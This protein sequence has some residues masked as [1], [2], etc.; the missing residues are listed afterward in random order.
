MHNQ[1][2]DRPSLPGSNFTGVLLVVLLLL[3][4]QGCF[5]EGGFFDGLMECDASCLLAQYDD[6][7]CDPSDPCG[8]VGDGFCDVTYCAQAVDTYFDDADDCGVSAECAGSCGRGRFDACTCAPD[9]P[10]GWVGDGYCDENTC[11]GILPGGYFDDSADCQGA[12]AACDGDCAAM[13]YTTCTCGSSD[14]C[15]WANDGDCDEDACA[16]VSAGGYFDD[17]AD[18]GGGTQPTGDDTFTVTAVRD[19]LDNQDLEIMV[20]GLR[21]L[22]Y[23]AS[24]R[25]TNVT[26][27][28]M[29]SYLGQNNTILY[30]TGHGFNGEVQ[31]AD[32]SITTSG[33]TIN[34]ENTIFATCLTLVESW[35]SNFGSTAQTVLG[36][37]KVSFD[38]ID[39][40][41]ATQFLSAIGSGRS[42]IEA[43]YQ[44]NNG[45]Y[46]VSDRWAGYVR[47][48]GS[49]VEYSARSERSPSAGADLLVEDIDVVRLGRQGS[50][51]V[52]EALLEDDRVFERHDSL[53]SIGAAELSSQFLP[54]GWEL[55]GPSRL[56]REQAMH[57]AQEF[58]DAR[59]GG[60]SPDAVLDRVTE[61]RAAADGEPA[62]TIGYS[63][64]WSRSIEGLPVRG[65]RIADHISVLVGPDGIAA[66]S[67]FWPDLE[68]VP[69]SMD[70]GAELLSVRDAT[71]L[72]ADEIARSA[73]GELRLLSA[74]LVYGTVGPNHRQ[75][76]LVP[77]YELESA[78][79]S[80]VVIDALTGRP[81]L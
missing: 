62:A 16:Q 5:E 46:D 61:V 81:L 26:T 64:R 8:W 66:W 44:A 2:H 43:W 36:Y 38:S 52:S 76:T 25:D 65:N 41:V 37:T 32:G 30:H 79:G 70:W 1:N 53:V 23:A 47:E 58:V 51:W 31:T 28:N 60:L 10:C 22:G 35:A 14:P 17:S 56:T 3:P 69:A 29:R 15:G 39:N 67:R 4:T 71:V 57:T 63:I 11:A 68:S 72:A 55:L 13:R 33:I 27:S 59:F 21:N 45:I 20:S 19:D 78:D 77:A 24:V 9:D 34:V 73:K 7:T 18:C 75:L 6:C 74:R 12:T 54:G 80:R 48:G 42:Y 50:L 40:D 49:I